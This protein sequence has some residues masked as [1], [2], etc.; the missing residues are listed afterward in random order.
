MIPCH[1]LVIVI[2]VPHTSTSQTSVSHRAVTDPKE[3]DRAAVFALDHRITVLVYGRV[4]ASGSPDEI[5]ANPG[6]RQADL[7]EQEAVTHV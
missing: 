5:R 7:G 1:S 3:K 6:V 2:P 4:I